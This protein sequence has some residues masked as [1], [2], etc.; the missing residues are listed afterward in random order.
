MNSWVS[1]TFGLI[2]YCA[3]VWLLYVV[4]V[5]MLMSKVQLDV[6]GFPTSV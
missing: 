1:S 3:I 4:L 5:S 6:N 2:V